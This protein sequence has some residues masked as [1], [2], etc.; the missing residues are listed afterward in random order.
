MRYGKSYQTL[1]ELQ[2]T[3]VEHTT[4]ATC[5]AGEAAQ[6]ARAWIEAEAYKREL[7]GLP[8]LKPAERADLM[9][10]ANARTARPALNEP[11]EVEAEPVEVRDSF[12][13]PPVTAPPTPEPPS[14][15]E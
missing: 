10:R 13:S 14:P 1:C 8:R 5:R 2:Q 7:R 6:C 12:R 3:L 4:A 11:V 15:V 9:K